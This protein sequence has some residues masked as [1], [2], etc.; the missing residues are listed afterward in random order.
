MTK[1]EFDFDILSIM[2][3]E[4]VF[5][6]ISLNDFYNEVYFGTEKNLTATDKIALNAL[7]DCPNVKRKVYNDFIKEEMVRN[8]VELMQL[9][10][11]PNEASKRYLI[12]SKF[13]FN[14]SNTRSSLLYP[15]A[16]LVR[17]S[18]PAIDSLAG[19][20]TKT[21]QDE[22]D[23]RPVYKHSVNPNY[24]YYEGESGSL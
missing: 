23:F 17:T 2:Q 5:G 22:R 12:S 4:G 8:Y 20:Y 6:I 19:V 11:H 15:P 18:D 16:F 1:L 7:Y 3:Y 13:S 21:G 9:K 24:I 10:I 14:F